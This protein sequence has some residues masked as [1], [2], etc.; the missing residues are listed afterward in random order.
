MVTLSKSEVE[1]IEKIM[2]LELSIAKK[3]NEYARDNVGE[4]L[5]RV[6]LNASQ[7][8]EANYLKLLSCLE[9]YTMV[10]GGY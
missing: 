9:E 8:H 3:Y 5:R 2:E 1:Y 10:F 6:F 4:Q 7:I